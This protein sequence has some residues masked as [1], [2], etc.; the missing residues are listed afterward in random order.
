VEL[1]FVKKRVKP[2]INLGFLPVRPETN[3]KKELNEN[4]TTD[5]CTV[6]THPQES[7]MLIIHGTILGRKAKI[8]ID[9]G[10]S[11]NFVSVK[12]D[13][14]RIMVCPLYGHS[15]ELSDIRS[16]FRVASSSHILDVF[17]I[18]RSYITLPSSIS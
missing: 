16:D 14:F 5:Q 4:P 1:P 17:I 12:N 3:L 7:R 9:S 2:N 13:N 11:S 10:S 8:L 6:V 15:C 18:Q